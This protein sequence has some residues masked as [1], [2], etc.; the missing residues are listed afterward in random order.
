MVPQHHGGAIQKPGQKHTLHTEVTEEKQ[1][2]RIGPFHPVQMPL[3]AI[4]VVGQNRIKL[5]RHIP[6]DIPD[7][8]RRICRSLEPPFRVVVPGILHPAFRQQVPAKP[9]GVEGGGGLIAC[10]KFPQPRADPGLGPN[11]LQRQRGGIPCPAQRRGVIVPIGDVFQA[12]AQQLC[13]PPALFRQGVAG[14]VR[15]GVADNINIHKGT[16]PLFFLD[17]TAGKQ[18]RQIIFPFSLFLRFRLPTI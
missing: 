4:A 11:L 3:P 2:V 13:L 17:Y 6:I 10:V 12:T 7:G 1:I 8:R 16:A 15:L 5:P 9:R 14:I 18:Q